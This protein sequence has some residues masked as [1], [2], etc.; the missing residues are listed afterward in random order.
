[1]TPDRCTMTI[2]NVYNSIKCVM[3]SHALGTLYLRVTIIVI[4][5]KTK[6][7]KCFKTLHAFGHYSC[8]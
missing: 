3:I 1:M 7:T 8:M 4:K 5:I 2:L 6:P